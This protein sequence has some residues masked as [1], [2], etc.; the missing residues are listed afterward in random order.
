M[1]SNGYILLVTVKHGCKIFCREIN[2]KSHLLYTL[3][4]K[5]LQHRFVYLGLNEVF[6]GVN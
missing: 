3:L 2:V 5:L 6:T 1:S 4:F